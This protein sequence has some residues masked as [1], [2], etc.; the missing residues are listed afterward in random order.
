MG[1]PEWRHSFTGK[2]PPLIA[3]PWHSPCAGKVGAP[4]ECHT[5]WV[6][7]W[8]S[9]VGS[10]QQGQALRSGGVPELLVVFVLV[11]APGTDTDWHSWRPSPLTFWDL[12]V[13]TL[14]ADNPLDARMFRL[15]HP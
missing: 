4:A 11:M 3:R 7:R 1:L 9:R 12:L 8:R 15:G 14:C 5:H 13:R 10:A 6:Q 2:A